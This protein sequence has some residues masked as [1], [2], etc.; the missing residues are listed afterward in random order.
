M[1]LEDKKMHILHMCM[2]LLQ[3]VRRGKMKRL[4]DSYKEIHNITLSQEDV[5]KYQT[6]KFSFDLYMNLQIAHKNV[7]LW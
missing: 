1:L 5:A 4:T 3:I 7:I 6:Y 2:L